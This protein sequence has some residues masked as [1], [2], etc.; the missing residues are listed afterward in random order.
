VESLDGQLKD[1][2]R[3]TGDRDW[4]GPNEYNVVN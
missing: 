2:G 3:A 1:P 4:S